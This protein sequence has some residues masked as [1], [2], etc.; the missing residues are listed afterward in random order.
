MAEIRPFKGVRYNKTKVDDI[1]KVISPPYDIISGAEQKELY[2]LSPYN[3]VRL[4]LN[5]SYPED[6]ENNNRYTRAGRLFRE[7]LQE[8]ILKVDEE[9]SIYPYQQEYISGGATKRR[10]G[11]ISLFK[12]EPF[13][14][15]SIYAHENTLSQPKEDRI[16]LTKD[17]KANLSPVFCIFKGG[18]GIRNILNPFLKEE[19][20]LNFRHS[21]N[22]QNRLWR[23][24]DKEAISNLVK[25][26]K[27]KKIVIADGHHRYE[28]ALYIKGLNPEYAY[29][30]LYL[31]DLD[32]EEITVLPTHRLLKDFKKGADPLAMAQGAFDIEGKDNV[33]ELLSFM[34]KSSGKSFGMYWNRRFYLLNYKAVAV[35][36]QSVDVDI[37]HNRLIE[38]LLSGLKREELLDYTRDPEYAVGEVNKGNYKLAFFLRPPEVSE[39]VDLA[40]AGRKAP[41]KT[42]YFYPKLLTGLVI[43]KFDDGLL[44]MSAQADPVLSELW[45]NEKD[46]AYDEQ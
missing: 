17:V 29:V 14:E 37:I 23:I 40:F 36:S 24:S 9:L 12:L 35:D 5:K 6:N 27:D 45:N 8:G 44:A 43:H 18:G 11:F 41:Q 30:M 19:P 10:T 42:T 4:I 16:L 1:S 22:T 3:I 33:K 20:I 28:T 15:E 7:W 39:V 32:S 2:A 25:L 13:G 38:P 26:L 21:D 34:D 31:L 46:S